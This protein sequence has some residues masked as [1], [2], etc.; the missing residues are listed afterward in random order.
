MGILNPVD[1]LNWQGHLPMGDPTSD[2]GRSTMG[3]RV[4]AGAVCSA[5]VLFAHT[6]WSA[7]NAWSLFA[8]FGF[9]LLATAAA[10]T[11]TPSTADH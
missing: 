2:D 1:R 3:M 4:F 6:A 8:G 10:T 5:L 11:L 9:V 7:A